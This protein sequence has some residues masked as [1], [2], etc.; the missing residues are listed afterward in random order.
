MNVEREY[1]LPSK[2]EPRVDEPVQVASLFYSKYVGLRFLC[3]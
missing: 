3:K 2:S 1:P